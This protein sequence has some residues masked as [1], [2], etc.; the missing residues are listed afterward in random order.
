MTLDFSKTCV[1]PSPMHLFLHKYLSFIVVPIKLT[2]SSEICIHHP[3][4]V[5][6]C[7][8]IIHLLW[9]L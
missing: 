6:F 9:N 8:S 1:H 2:P 5:N 7:T 4:Y 3:L